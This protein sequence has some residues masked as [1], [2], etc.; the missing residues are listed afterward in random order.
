[1]LRKSLLSVLKHRN[2]DRMAERCEFAI[3]EGD[4]VPKGPLDAQGENGG[5]NSEGNDNDEYREETGDDGAEEGDQDSVESRLIIRLFCKHGKFLMPY[6]V[7]PKLMH[8]RCREDSPAAP[9]PP[10][11]QPETRH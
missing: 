8:D 10:S 6:I 3:V 1:M 4:P 11:Q 7:H 5:N 2:L 9:L